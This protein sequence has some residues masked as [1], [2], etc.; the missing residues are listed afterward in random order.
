MK[1]IW[2]LENSKNLLERLNFVKRVKEIIELKEK[3]DIPEAEKSSSPEL[4]REKGFVKMLKEKLSR[5]DVYSQK[6]VYKCSGC[7]EPVEK[8]C[9]GETGGDDWVKGLDL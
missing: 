1:Q 2:E 7:H 9:C 3:V 6:S 4:E 5:F 8:C